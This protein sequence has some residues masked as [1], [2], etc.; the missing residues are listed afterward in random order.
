MNKEQKAELKHLID[1]YNTYKEKGYTYKRL[2][3]IA[4]ILYKD[5]KHIKSK[6]E[7]YDK[8][9]IFAMENYIKKED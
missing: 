1:V 4:M 8:F 9:R 2:L 6:K 7:V 5:N 3:A